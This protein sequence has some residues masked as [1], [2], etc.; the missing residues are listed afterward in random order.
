[1]LRGTFQHELQR[2]RQAVLDELDIVAGQLSLV[3]DVLERSDPDVA[4]Q[5]IRGDEKVDERY[6][7][8]QID[9]VT[10]IARQQPVASDLRLVTALLHISRM[11]ER[12]GDQ[13]VNV[14][15]L[16]SVAGPPPTGA[17]EFLDCLMSMGRATEEAVV[18]A[19]RALREEDID[20]ARTLAKRDA[21]VN[22]LNRSCF[23]LAIELGDAEDR[24]RWATAMILV[25]RALERIADNAVDIGAHLGF[26]V[27][28]SFGR[29]DAAVDDG[30]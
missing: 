27:T 21:E 2:L 17:Q 25:A 4:E 7:Q 14:A 9:L 30:S 20:A 5:V 13:C 23:G 6:G 18:L 19:A 11:V 15:K 1:M 10:V 3:R 26:A 28:G 12:M 29:R 16:V 22:E 8:L 24:R